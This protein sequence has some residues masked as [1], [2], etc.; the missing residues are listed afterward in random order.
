MSWGWGEIKSVK[1]RKGEPRGKE[2]GSE[3]REN[4]RGKLAMADLIFI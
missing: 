4:S 2:G 1:G 3:D